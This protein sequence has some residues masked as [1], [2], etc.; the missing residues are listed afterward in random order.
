MVNK[1]EKELICICCPKGCHLKV[2]DKSLVVS[3]NNR[4]RGAEY[5][6]KEVTKEERHQ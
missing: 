3:G 2:D 4:P 1:M 5:G 6:V